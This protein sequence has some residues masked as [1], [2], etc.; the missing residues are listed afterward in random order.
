MSGMLLCKCQISIF[1]LSI[2]WLPWFPVTALSRPH[3][4]LIIPL[5]Y[6]SQ[7][8][9]Y[10]AFLDL[11]LSASKVCHA[12][13]TGMSLDAKVDWGISA[14]YMWSDTDWVRIPVQPWLHLPLKRVIL[15]PSMTSFRFRL[16]LYLSL[17]T[18]G[19]M[20]CFCS[21]SCIAHM[22]SVSSVWI[23]LF[24]LVSAMTSSSSVPFPVL[25]FESCTFFFNFF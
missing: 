19:S 2:G 22:S 10:S 24:F 16:Q 5:I 9:M 6:C 23:T 21:F 25:F 17:H 4:F 8:N 1:V 20:R 11:S 18:P 13:A 3:L 7:R 15:A 12:I 14:S